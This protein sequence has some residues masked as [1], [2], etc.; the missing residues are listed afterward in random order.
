MPSEK[1]SLKGEAAV[2]HKKRRRFTRDS[3]SI[4]GVTQTLDVYVYKALMESGNY[5]YSSA[6]SL[7]Q[8]TLGCIL[9]IAA[10]FVVR[11]IDP[12]SGIF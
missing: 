6:V 11:K 5:H 4:I 7:L 10:N 3:G 9:L 2:V 1:L 12:E 8:S